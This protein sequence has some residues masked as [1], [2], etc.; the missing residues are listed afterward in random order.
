MRAGHSS[1]S[2]GKITPEGMRRDGAT[3]G[4]QPREIAVITGYGGKRSILLS[5]IGLQCVCRPEPKLL[6]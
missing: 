6:V 4:H 3:H 2:V 1:V 5:C